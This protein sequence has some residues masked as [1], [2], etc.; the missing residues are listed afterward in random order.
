MSI[1]RRTG[2]G[3]VHRPP[4]LSVTPQLLLVPLGRDRA[5]E[6][7]RGGGAGPLAERGP[8]GCPPGGV[9]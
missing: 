5:G 1:K 7:P 8:L 9:R 4:R 6:G 3:G 2:A